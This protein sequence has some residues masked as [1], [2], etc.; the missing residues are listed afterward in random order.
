[1]RSLTILESVDLGIDANG[2]LISKS[3]ATWYVCFVPP[4]EPQ[5]WHKYFHGRHKHCFAIK[6]ESNGSWTLFEPWWSRILVSGIS[7]GEAQRF[8][9]WAARGDVLRVVEHIPGKSSQLRIWMTCG[10]LVAHLLGRSYW[11]WTPHQLY[12]K[13]RAEPGAVPVNVEYLA[14]TIIGEENRTC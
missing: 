9:A 5:W 12:R 11:V 13:L 1:M 3:P 6:L 2:C 4:I 10:A 14:V 7:A 8:L